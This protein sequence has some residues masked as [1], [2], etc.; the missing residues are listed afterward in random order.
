MHAIG[1]DRTYLLTHP[2]AQLTSEQ[3]AVYEEWLARRERHEPIQYIIG[4]QEFFGLKLRV[5]PDVLIPRPETE[6]LVEAALE[7]LERNAPL[8]IAD[9][10]TGSGAIAVALAHALPMAHLTA[11]DI[12]PAA[13]AVARSNAEIHSVSGHIRFCE[14]DLLEAVAG[15][16]FDMIVSNPPYVAENEILEAQ[17]RDY[18]PTSALFAGATGLDVYERLIPQAQA[19]LKLG[20]WLLLEIGH[21]QRDAL[22]QLLSGWSSVSFVADLQAILRVACAQR[23]E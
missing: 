17:V 12:S 22:A 5:T 14:S 13:L 16:S 3:A 15:E 21:G 23:V 10:G 20:G 8:R 19:A 11:L 18:E 7:R 9:I 2:E 6:H 1:R 4:E